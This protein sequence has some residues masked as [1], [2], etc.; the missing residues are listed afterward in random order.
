MALTAN[1]E[2]DRYADQELR[3]VALAAGVEVFKGALVEWDAAGFAQPVSGAGSF[4]GLA[5]EAM[6]NTGGAAGDA[7]CRVFTQGDFE[8]PLA[9][10]T[11]ADVGRRVYAGDDATLTFDPQDAIPVGWVRGLGASGHIVLRL[12]DAGE[13]MGARIEHHAASFALNW[14]QSGGIH[15]NRGASGVITATLPQNPPEG[16]V[17]RFACM[18]DQPLRVAPG[19]AGGI[20]VKG[21]KQADNKYVAIGDIGDFLELVADGNGDWLAVASIGGADADLSVEA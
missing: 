16:T 10:A 12:A 6:D 20:Y 8:F 11:Q 4:A 13:S 19:A 1:R 15:T 21:A 2:V 3:T 5:Y 7:R 9:G 17:Y 14:R 18:A